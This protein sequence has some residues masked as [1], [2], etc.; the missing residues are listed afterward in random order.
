[1][2]EL[3]EFQR[4]AAD[5]I[6]DRYADYWQD[7]AITGSQRHPRAL[8]FF[9]SLASITASGKTVILAAAVADIAMG[10]PVKPVVM[11]ISRGKVVVE[12]SYVNLADG[13]KYHHLLGEA[14]VYPLASY[15][16]AVVAEA[17]TPLVYFATAGTF[18]QKDKEQGS[19]LI[20]KC[21]IDHTD[22]STWDSLKER[23][24]QQGRRRPLIVVY[25]EAQNLSDQQTDLL[26]ELEPQALLLASATMRL[27]SRLAS[28]MHEARTK[29]SHDESWLV[30][31]V[32]AVAVADAGL[33]KSTVL[34]AGYRSPMDE[35]LDALIDDLRQAEADAATY[36]L[37]GKPKAIYVSQTNIVEGNAYQTDNHKQPFFQRQAPPILIWRYLVEHHHVDPASIAVYCT[38]KF[39]RNYPPP[40]EFCL[41][42]GG[43]N[44][45]RR[46]GCT[47]WRSTP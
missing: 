10:L 6:A 40:D 30:T 45:Y 11:W 27:P 9:Q 26:L 13:G 47:A 36:R 32:D 16:K 18:N 14:D 34:L 21:D 19:R 43:D 39:D 8:P 1:M 35:T 24:D 38:L 2:I 25:D 7:P 4:Q 44:D 5:T 42:T 12:Q 29:T 17:A 20:F 22:Q 33:V 37:P 23:S 41:F 28:E 15:D 46:Q 31:Q 3:F